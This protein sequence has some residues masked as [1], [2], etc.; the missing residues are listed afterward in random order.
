MLHTKDFKFLGDIVIKNVGEAE[1][2]TN[3]VNITLQGSSVVSASGSFT[4]SKIKF[5]SAP[6]SDD[7]FDYC[8]VQGG[9]NMYDRT[10]TYTTTPISLIVSPIAYIWQDVGE[11]Y[12]R[13]TAG[14]YK[15]NGGSTITPDIDYANASQI[16][17]NDGD[18]ITLITT[19]D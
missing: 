8:N 12:S 15:I 3:T 16:T 9:K 4:S 11:Y 1:E 19:W 2:E 14:G 18:I 6:T 7:D 13:D 10:G 17:L 5:G